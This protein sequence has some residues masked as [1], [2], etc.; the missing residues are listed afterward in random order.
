[1]HL[2]S[3][4]LFYCFSRLLGGL[5]STF[6]HDDNTTGTRTGSG[7][8]VTTRW[9]QRMAFEVGSPSPPLHPN[10]GTL[11]WGRGGNKR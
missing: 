4:I 6:L 11:S 7:D 1:M 5:S 3:G 2:S 8:E 10:V 9:R